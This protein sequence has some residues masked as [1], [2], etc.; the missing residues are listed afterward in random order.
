M[1]RLNSKL[2]AILAIAAIIV[3]VGVHVV[4][5]IQNRRNADALLKRAEEKKTTDPDNALFLYEHYR[6]SKPDDLERNAEY[7]M[8]LAEVVKSHLDG[9]RYQ[10]AVDAL[11][12]A[13]VNSDKPADLRRKLIELNIAFHQFA[14]A[15][16]ELIQLQKKGQSDPQ[17]DLLLAQCYTSTA[18]YLEAVQLLE[19]LVGYNPA[20][21][22]FDAAHATAPHELQAYAML[23]AVLREKLTDA[24]MPDRLD[25]ANRVID[26]LVAQNQDSAK[27]LLMQAQSLADAKLFDKAKEAVQ[28]ALALAPEDAQV[29]LEA[30]QMERT[31]KNFDEAQQLVAKGLKLYP[32]D[33]HFYIAWAES[34]K[35]PAE[36]KERLDAGL[37]ALPGDINLLAMYFDIQLQSSDFDGARLT[38]KKLASSRL[39]ED[40]QQ[41][42]EACLAIA[43][44]NYRQAAQQL[45]HLLTVGRNP[46]MSRNIELRLMN[47]Y[48]QLNQYDLALKAASTL[49][50]TAEGELG[51]ASAQVGQGKTTEALK[52]FEKIA[53]WIGQG[54]NPNAMPAVVKQIL[55]LRIAEQMRKPKSEREWKDIDALFAKMR[56]QNMLKE[57]AASLEEVSILTRKEETEKAHQI[58]QDLLQRY[59][60]NTSVVGMAIGLAL[61]QRQPAEALRII[62]AAPEEMRQEPR[63]FVDRM[64]AM[65]IVGGTRDALKAG[66]ASI[67]ADIEKLPQDK[68][69]K[70]Y[71]NLGQAYIRVGDF[72]AAKKLWEQAAQLDPHNPQVQ[73]SRF[74][75]AQDMGELATM[76]Q[77]QEWFEKEDADDPAQIKLLQAAVMISSVI[78]ELNEKANGSLQAGVVLDNAQ[79]RTLL[80]ARDLLQQV[81]NLRPGWAE[82]PKWVAQIDALENKTD[83]AIEHLHQMLEL[84]Q[85]NSAMVKQLVKLLYQRHRNDEALQLLETY[86]TLVTGDAEMDRIQAMLDYDAGRYK[87]ALDRLQGQFSKDSTNAGEHL[88]HGELL[89]SVGKLDESEAEL[90]RAIELNP[91]WSDPWVKLIQL[92]ATMQK[93]PEEAL[94]ILHEAQIKLPADQ[95]ALVLAQGYEFLNDPTQAEQSYLSALSAA[96]NNLALL[97]QMAAFYLRVGLVEKAQKYL[98]QILNASSAQQTDPDSYGWARRTKAELMAKTGDYRQFRNAI[99]LLSPPGGKPNADDMATRINLLFERGDPASS[100]QALRVLDDLKK[101]RPLTWR[102]HVIL[103]RLYEQVD[104]WPAAR[105]EMLSLLSQPSPDPAVYITFVE[106]L[107]RR[108]LPDQ[109]VTWLQT[110]Q[111]MGY[112]KSPRVALLAARTLAMQGHVAEGGSLLLRLLPSERPLPKEQ[113]PLLQ[114]I[115][116][117]MNLIGEYDQAEKLY[118]ELVGYEPAK[119]PLLAAFYAQR[120]KVDMALNLCEQNRKNL[121]PAAMIEIGL[122]ALHQ[123]INPPTPEQVQ[124]VDQWLERALQT[125]PDSW[126]LQMELSE[127]RDFQ[128]RYDDAEKLYRALLARS[129]VL[130]NQRAAL[131]NNLAFLL[132]MQGRN[133][134]EAIKLIDEAID[135]FGPQ[136]D[137]LD[138]RGVI[139]LS[140]GD[141]AQALTDLSDCIIATEPKAVQFVH[142][143]K[144]QAK[145][146]DEVAAR[147]SLQRA[148]DLKFNPDDLSP[149][150]KSEYQALLKQLNLTL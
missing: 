93:K 85:P 132:A 20:A 11:Q 12:Q 3:M 145:S 75:L 61:Q 10:A 63:I 141:V 133:Q 144:A 15:E 95:S 124:R 127:L 21:K 97:R 111:S 136:S 113:W 18:R 8:L 100:R 2:L 32:K 122:T 57:P 16:K 140:K 27:A 106:M 14:P 62:D 23:A 91:D 65:F 9:R 46:G 135:T 79:K 74:E 1:K 115:A 29:L 148:K 47:C 44:G 33:N 128:R 89:A 143:A 126:A 31:S 129:D 108:N 41:Y 117:D 82:Q 116:A 146:K 54:N 83:D 142:L 58:I 94:Q 103:A 36:A 55:D 120:G 19:S 64:D 69:L 68:R 51:M 7:A 26:Q 37:K 45:E 110:L 90:R 139:Y 28:K 134:D 5:G 13:I 105:E 102:E 104:N 40:K 35:T 109:A 60:S 123:N 30:I 118:K 67:A 53:H 34:S 48:L 52:H 149:A 98:D 125:D 101:L 112:Q 50:D 80:Q 137:M 87:E 73:L 39:P 107:L 76:K 43:E 56:E 49:Q 70:L 17:S 92:K 99:E 119:M 25:L 6:A 150:E 114:E 86:G 147:A 71:P 72:P 96:P 4:H 138:T 77:I 121:S 59:P 131:L 130:A 78:Q 81:N 84:G 66:L 42:C 24:Q 88:L 22:S 38:L